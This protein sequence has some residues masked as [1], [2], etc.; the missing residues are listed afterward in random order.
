MRI[1][2]VLLLLLVSNVFMTGQKINVSSVRRLTTKSDGEFRVAGVLPDGKTLLITGTDYKG[3]SLMSVS[4]RSMTVISN[5]KGAGYQPVFSDDGSTIFYRKDDFS[6]PVKQSSLCS[7]NRSNGETKVLAE[8]SAR[9]TTP[10]V[11]G[12]SLIY[13]ADGK[14]KMVTFKGEATKGYAGFTAVLNEDMTPVLYQNGERRPFT[15]KGEGMYI[16]VSL[17]PDK[18]KLLFNFRGLE[19]Y[20][21]DLNGRILF[22]AGRLNAP[23][24][25]TNDIIIGMEDH[26]D[27]YLVISSDLVAYSLVTGAKRNLTRTEDRAEMYPF[28]LPGGRGL[29]FSTSEG[30]LYIMKIKLR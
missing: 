10:V 12:G 15:P 6:Q 29:V 8:P 11:A 26:D 1:K 22:S 19:T 24:W 3:L 13:A 21:S 23:A 17:S 16:W 18:T 5:E 25:L 30:E 9:V 14:E 7:F 4:G 20:V 27:G 28:P 2:L